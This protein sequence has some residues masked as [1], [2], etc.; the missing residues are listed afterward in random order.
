MA[1]FEAL[2][3]RDA[4]NIGVGGLCSVA[5]PAEDLKIVGFV[6]SSKSDGKN[7]INV[8]RFAGFN[9]LRAVGALAF[10]LLNWPPFRPDT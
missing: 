7:M 8:P 10:P 3:F 5:G 6:R 4:W 1:R 2:G 9:L